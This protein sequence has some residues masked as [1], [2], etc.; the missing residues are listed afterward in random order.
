VAVVEIHLHSLL[1]WAID[2]DEKSVARLGP[3]TSR[4]SLSVSSE[5]EAG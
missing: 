1:I 4:E 5:Q 3:S 2:G